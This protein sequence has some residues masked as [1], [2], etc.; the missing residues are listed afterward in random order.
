M[1]SFLFEIGFELVSWEAGLGLGS[2]AG[3]YFGNWAG[4]GGAGA[5]AGRSALGGVATGT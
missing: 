4:A 2:G 5:G 1:T 3:F